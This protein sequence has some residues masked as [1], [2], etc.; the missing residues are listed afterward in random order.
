MGLLRSW[1][2]QLADGL[3]PPVCLLCGA[4]P[5]A[6]TSLCHRCWA[7]LPRVGHACE[8]CAL[9]LP[10]AALPDGRP[11]GDALRCCSDCLIH[12]P[13]FDS[14]CAAFRYA[15]PVD[16][17]VRALKYRHRLAVVPLLGDA[18][19]GL[20]APEV[21]HVIG[22]PMHPAAL[23][24]RGFNQAVELARVCAGQWRRPLALNLV[25]RVRD[26]P[27]QAGLGRAARKQ[28]L[29]AAFVCRHAMVG[30]RVVI[31]DDVMTSGASVAA[32]AETLKAAGAAEVHVRLAARTEGFR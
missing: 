29:R 28:N 17:L 23:Q 31:V 20:G 22:M 7:C 18:V 11:Q 3:L 21:D 1:W 26:T 16:R 4:A 15:F 27:A 5:E 14:A 12:P 13:P 8:R 10:D 9:P 32:L 30:A 25:D 19:A 2:S 6:D 24:R